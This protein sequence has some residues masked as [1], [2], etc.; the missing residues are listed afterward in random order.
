MTF[1][2]SVVSSFDLRDSWFVNDP[3]PGLRRLR[4]AAPVYRSDSGDWVLTRYAEVVE[5]LRDP[6]LHTG[7]G[8]T[9]ET[10]TLYGEGRVFDYLTRRLSRY[11]PPDHTRLRSLVSP[12]FTPSR[13]KALRGHVVDITN[14][15]LD[16]VQD[17]ATFDF[18]D[19]VANRLA[20]LVIC[21]L[22]GIPE[23]DRAVHGSWTPAIQRAMASPS[24]AAHRAAG[25]A[26]AAA[27]WAYLED[28][29][30]QR[31]AQPRSD[32][33]SALILAEERGQRLSHDEL[34]ATLIFLFSAGHSTTRDLLS[35]GLVAMLTDRDQF[36]KLVA[37]P[38]LAAA[39]VDESLRFES[40]ITMLR[41]RARADTVIGNTRIR[42]GDNVVAVLLAA[43][44]DPDRF[45]EPDR[46]I[47][48]RPEN[49]PVSFGG[50][51]HFCVGAALARME[52]E[53]A[54][55]ALATR[56]PDLA[57]A[58]SRIQWRDTPIFR[59]PL[60]VIVAPNFST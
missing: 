6:L 52:A 55:T 31:R 43:N 18:V 3:H 41:R 12:P 13:M 15:L 7:W 29:A 8:S 49:R 34:I 54:L 48:D 45:D 44:R 42:A 21:E 20:S 60:T 17:M 27:K 28:L 33:L 37:D 59:G 36:A 14:G 56:I 23:Q 30:E 16:Q 19:A 35:S 57:L 2:E 26:A 1:D 58:D 4:A 47:I 38:S 46:F 51:I 10:R 32:L 5:A 25:E 39:A 24:V 22:I 40:P 9:E 53:V 50:G 11:N